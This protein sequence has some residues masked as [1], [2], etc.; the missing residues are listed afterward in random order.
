VIV[1][2][3]HEVDVL[4]PK[5]QLDGLHRLVHQDN[6]PFGKLVPGVGARLD[7]DAAHRLYPLWLTMAA[8]DTSRG[9]RERITA[10]IPQRVSVGPQQGTL[11]KDVPRAFSGSK[12]RINPPERCQARR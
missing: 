9:N 3:V 8:D 4:V 11:H 2:L 7:C 1:V 12:N 10:K 5:R 6:L